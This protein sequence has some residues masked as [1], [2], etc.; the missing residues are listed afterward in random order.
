MVVEQHPTLQNITLRTAKVRYSC[1]KHEYVHIVYK[2]RYNGAVSFF[3]HLICKFLG[4]SKVLM[5]RLNL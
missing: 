2:F 5:Q 4:L 3:P 1:N